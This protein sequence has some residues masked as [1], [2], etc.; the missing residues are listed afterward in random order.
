[1]DR[2]PILI[3]PLTIIAI[4]TVIVTVIV[5]VIVSMSV[6]LCVLCVVGSC[7]HMMQ[8]TLN[9]TI[10]LLVNSPL[11]KRVPN[12]GTGLGVLGQQYNTGARLIETV[13]R[14]QK[15]RFGSAAPPIDLEAR[16]EAFGVG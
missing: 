12:P 13:H 8:M 6:S 5:I 1:M 9:D 16:E 2:P 7:E 3:S 10:I 11:P 14:Q 15:I 4:V